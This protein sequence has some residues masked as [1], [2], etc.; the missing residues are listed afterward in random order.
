[1]VVVVSVEVEVAMEE[2]EEM[3]ITAELQ[4]DRNETIL[5]NS[6]EFSTALSVDSLPMSFGR[7]VLEGGGFSRTLHRHKKGMKI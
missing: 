7:K 6:L 3:G 1:M 5:R 2:D 4:L